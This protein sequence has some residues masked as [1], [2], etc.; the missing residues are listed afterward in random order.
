[1]FWIGNWFGDV[2]SG[3]GDVFKDLLNTLI[4]GLNWALT[5]PFNAINNILKGIR[6][7]NILGGKPFGWVSTVNVP[8]IPMLA[9][10]GIVDYGQMFVAREAGAELVGGFGNKTGVM[11][12][13][14]IVDA[15]SAGVANAVAQV[16]S[17]VDFGGRGEEQNVNVFLDGRQ[18]S[19]AI[20]QTRR[21]QGVSIVRGGI[22]N[23][24]NKNK[25][26]R[27]KRPLYIRRSN[28]H[29]S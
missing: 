1:M 14:Q 24:F 17:Q 9:N 8:Q 23:G 18:I 3:I 4:K 13:E 28:F 26:G 10:G 16:M 12:N 27:F 21:Q 19:S 15:V 5:Q 29:A 11:N 7:I 2:G 20:E 6:D 25:W 22:N